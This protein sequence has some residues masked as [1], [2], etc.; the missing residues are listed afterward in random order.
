MT[1]PFLNSLLFAAQLLKV[2]QMYTLF[3]SFTLF[4]LNSWKINVFNSSK[5][6][7]SKTIQEFSRTPENIQG[8]KYVF[9]GS[10]TQHV[11]TENSRT[12]LG[13]R[14]RMVTLAVQQHEL[15]LE[16]V[17]VQ[18]N[19]EVSSP[20]VIAQCEATGLIKMTKIFRYCARAH[21]GSG[22]KHSREVYDKGTR[23]SCNVCNK[24]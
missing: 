18:T 22:P 20:S 5:T 23:E 4:I 24:F 19:K 8:Q 12:I 21:V 3:C 17:T 2:E 14:G 9:Q 13:A 10:R 15:Q 6:N 11:L 1:Q 7:S 16:E